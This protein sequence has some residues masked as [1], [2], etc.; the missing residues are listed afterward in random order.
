MNNG[1]YITQSDIE[2]YNQLVKS[3]GPNAAPTLDN[4]FKEI[5][6]IY[7]KILKPENDEFISYLRMEHSGNLECYNHSYERYLYIPFDLLKNENWQDLL[8]KE[9]DDKNKKQ[10]I[11]GIKNILNQYLKIKDKAIEIAKEYALLKN[12]RKSSIE[13]GVFTFMTSPSNI[14]KEIITVLF[15][16][17]SIA[18]EIDDQEVFIFPV[19]LLVIDDWKEKLKEY[20]SSEPELGPRYHYR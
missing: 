6:K 9:I 13:D 7:A 12:I 4:K 1:F 18:G 15:E 10:E 5:V 2:V 11:D 17:S 3:G 14:E 20:H 8:K 19:E 16:L